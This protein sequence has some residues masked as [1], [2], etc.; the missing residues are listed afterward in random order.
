MVVLWLVVVVGLASVALAYNPSLAVVHEYDDHSNTL[1][2]VA[3]AEQFD[4][5]FS[6]DQAGGFFVYQVRQE[7]AERITE[8]EAG[9]ALAVGQE[10]VYIAAA[11]TLWA[12]DVE[13]GELT[14]VTQLPAH[15]QSIAF[16]EA[17]EVVWSTGNGTVFGYHVPNGSEYTTYTEHTGG[18]QDIAVRGDYIATGTTWSDEVVVY[19]IAAEEVAY[20]P[21][22][23]N[24]VG[25]VGA[26][27]ITADDDLVVGTGADEGDVVGLFDLDDQEPVVQYREHTFSV[28]DVEYDADHDVIVSMGFDNTIKFYDVEADEVATV[29]Q[30][31][32]TIYAG[33]LDTRNDLLWFGDGEERSGTVTGLDVFFEE[34]TPT[35]TPVETTMSAATPPSTPERTTDEGAAPTPAVTPTASGED[36]AGFGVG[37]AIV[38]LIGAALMVRRID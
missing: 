24:D 6:L 38:A 11:D 5:V 18:L 22:L 8:F 3:Y 27:H 12:F 7:A 9:H 35:P 32:D 31:P 25:Q 1:V 4:L 17:R 34:P 23:P 16:D 33:D 2:D 19:D 29:Y 26:V 14:E 20:E 13:G 28:S 21:A 37:L 30:H 10:A 15:P 36:G